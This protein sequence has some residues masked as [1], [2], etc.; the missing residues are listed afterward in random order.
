MLRNDIWNDNMLLVQGVVCY[1]QYACEYDTIGERTMVSYPPPSQEYPPRIKCCHA[2]TS[3]KRMKSCSLIPQQLSSSPHVYIARTNSHYAAT[4]AT[5][6]PTRHHCHCFEHILHI[7]YFPS[8]FRAPLR[9]HFFHPP[10]QLH[11]NS[12]TVHT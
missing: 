6:P 1:A 11:P 8:P 7:S 10:L 4:T 12:H 9:P 3:T 2:S 5:H